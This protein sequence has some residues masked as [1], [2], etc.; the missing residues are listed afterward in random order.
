MLATPNAPTST[1]RSL[2]HRRRTTP[3]VLPTFPCWLPAPVAACLRRDASESLEA[4][5]A[6]RSGFARRLVDLGA[7][8]AEPA[9]VV[10]GVVCLSG[11]SLPAQSDDFLR[12]EAG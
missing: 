3:A 5:A 4:R 11:L 7:A 8:V 9:D 6:L 1:T 12:L 10:D 2:W